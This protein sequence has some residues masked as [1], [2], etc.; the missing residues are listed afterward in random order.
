MNDLLGILGWSGVSRGASWGNS[1]P[2]TQVPTTADVP[3]LLLQLSL[4]LSVC[5]CVCVCVR[6]C[7]C[8]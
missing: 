5:V 7:V 1:D 2:N 8:E 4:S 3:L 6:V